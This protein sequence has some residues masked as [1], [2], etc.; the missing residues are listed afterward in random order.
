MR[1]GD[2]ALANPLGGNTLGGVKNFVQKVENSTTLAAPVGGINAR[3]SIANMDPTDAIKLENFFPYT[4]GC[5]VRQGYM[6]H[7]YGLPGRVETVATHLTDLNTEYLLAF[8]NGGLYNVTGGGAAPAPLLT[9]L[10]NNRWQWV[11]FATA[12]GVFWVGVNGQDN[13]II[14]DHNMT[15]S[16]LVAG[17]GTDPWTISGADPKTFTSV[18]IHQMRLWFVASNSSVGYYLPPSSL[19]GVL[20][21]YP[22]GSLFRKGGWLVS[23]ASWTVDAGD[24]PDDRL[25]T[26]SSAGEIVVYAG[27]DPSTT[28][29]WGLCGV[30]FLGRPVGVRCMAKYG[31]DIAIL[32]DQGLASLNAILTSTTVNTRTS[33]FSDKIMNLIQSEIQNWGPQFGWQPLVYP[34]Q[35]MLILN[36]PD[37]NYQNGLQLVMNTITSAW[38]TFAGMNALCWTNY[39]AQIFYGTADGHVYQGLTG[40]LD[41]F[42]TYHSVVGTDINAVAITSFSYFQTPGQNKDFTMVRPTLVGV[43][44]PSVALQANMAFIT[45]DPPDCPVASTV[46]FPTWDG[47]NWDV[48][49]WT[50]NNRT[51]NDWFG[52]GGIAYAAALAMRVKAKDQVAWASTDWVFQIQKGTVI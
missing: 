40:F 22:F 1:F 23:Q 15:I 9:G 39:G 26:M 4:L 20:K 35:N 18:C 27:T 16:R 14:I 33:F 17:N 52:V 34:Q 48:T 3:D 47:A 49:A 29:T 31:G 30:F 12:G 7:T 44:K 13:P 6:V 43:N 19:Y 41:G 45:T 51:F 37:S 50:G 8:S 5:Q 38:T 46:G 21:T 42:D 36:V 2:S 11:S 28:T 10:T 25:V 24:G 32:C